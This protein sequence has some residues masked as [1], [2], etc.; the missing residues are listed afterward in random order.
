M[1]IDTK[2][3]EEA[4]IREVADRIMGDD[5]M[6]ERAKDAIS[7]RVDRLWKEQVAER[8]SDAVNTAIREGF[9]HSYQKVDSYGKPVGPKTTISAE[10]E[11]LIQG[12]WNQPVDKSGKPDSSTYGEKITRA[13]WVMMQIVADDFQKTMKQHVVNAAG[14]L[15]DGLRKELH[16]TTNRMLSEIFKVRSL[17]DQAD[18]K[19]PN[20]IDPEEKTKA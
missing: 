17:D 6:Y 13:Q 9:E 5:E 15:K 1:E 8:V 18:A 12:Y 4:V 10:L 11:K 20:I 2:R 14:W 3:I 16:Q 7:A 19:R